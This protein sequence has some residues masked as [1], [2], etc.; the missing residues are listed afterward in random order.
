M[1]HLSPACDGAADRH[2]TTGPD[3]G[4]NNGKGDPP[5]SAA[6]P[7]LSGAALTRREHQVAAAVA[8]GLSN[9]QIGAALSMSVKTVECHLSR[10]YRKTG[11][12]RATELTARLSGIHLT[13]PLGPTMTA[14]TAKEHQVARALLAGMTNRQAAVALHM[15][16]KTLEHQLTR[17]YRKLSIT[18]RRQLHA[19]MAQLPSEPIRHSPI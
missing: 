6:N 14:L 7:D 13:V 17:L 8:S 3:L 18:S 10:I 1:T 9:P 16:P 11:V 15:S 19:I 12:A 5:V 2:D 4:Q